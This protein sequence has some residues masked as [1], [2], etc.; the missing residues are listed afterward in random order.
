MTAPLASDST[1][2]PWQLRPIKAKLFTSLTHH[3]SVEDLVR[4]SKR[5]LRLAAFSMHRDDDLTFAPLFMLVLV[6]AAAALSQPFPKCGAFHY[7]APIYL[8]VI[9]SKHY[10]IEFLHFAF[11]GYVATILQF[12]RFPLSCIKY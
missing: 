2:R 9:L 6:K 10:R 3:P 7:L 1:L 5:H 11:T 12:L 4:A 8:S